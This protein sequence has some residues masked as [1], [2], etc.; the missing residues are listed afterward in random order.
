MKP[1]LRTKFTAQVLRRRNKISGNSNLTWPLMW[2]WQLVHKKTKEKRKKNEK[3]W[4]G[5]ER[6]AT[7]ISFTQCFDSSFVCISVALIC[8]QIE[9]N[10]F[11]WRWVSTKYSVIPHYNVARI[12]LTIFQVESLV[13]VSI[14]VIR[15]STESN[16]EWEWSIMVRFLVLNIKLA[17]LK[18]WYRTGIIMH[19]RFFGWI[20]RTGFVGRLDKGGVGVFQAFLRR[21]PSSASSTVIIWRPISMLIQHINPSL[22]NDQVH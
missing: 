22:I 2:K 21:I 5:W 17:P 15:S 19:Y 6:V 13:T 20:I 1:I 18:C 3:R 16:F 12:S 9:S 11:P 4:N 14:L 10:R 8:M 7:V